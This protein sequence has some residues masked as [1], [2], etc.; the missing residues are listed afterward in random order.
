MTQFHHMLDLIVNK[1]DTLASDNK[2]DFRE[3]KNRLSA[4]EKQTR[5]TNGRVTVLENVN[6]TQSEVK[7]ALRESTETHDV[8]MQ[9][10]REY[11]LSRRTVFWGA[12]GVIVTLM[13]GLVGA[14]D[15]ILGRWPI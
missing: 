4:V 12:A 15:V 5:L 3:V 9:Q 14:I 6:I 1:I 13:L 8:V 2:D 11:S 7:K 10:Q